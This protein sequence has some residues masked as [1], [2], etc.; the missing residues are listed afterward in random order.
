MTDAV[1]S[2]WFKEKGGL[3]LILGKEPCTLG[4]Y[5]SEGSEYGGKEKTGK[6]PKAQ[7]GGIEKNGKRETDKR[8]AKKKCHRP[9]TAE[10]KESRVPG[11]VPIFETTEARG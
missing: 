11:G 2:H 9:R 4:K 10:E 7:R 1:H 8:N 5:W 3:K 6:L